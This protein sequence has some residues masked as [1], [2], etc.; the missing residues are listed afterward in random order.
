VVACFDVEPIFRARGWRGMG[1]WRD[2]KDSVGVRSGTAVDQER[3]PF[4]KT[5]PGFYA[6]WRSCL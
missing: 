5:I 6:V 2:E 4:M 3:S 1:A